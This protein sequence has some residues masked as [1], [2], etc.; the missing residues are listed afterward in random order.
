M[1]PSRNSCKKALLKVEWIPSPYIEASVPFDPHRH[2]ALVRPAQSEASQARRF[3]QRRMPD[4]WRFA[5][6]MTN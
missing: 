6:Q 4:S 5:Q 3:L 2:L 1:Q